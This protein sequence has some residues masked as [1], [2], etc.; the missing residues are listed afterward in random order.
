MCIGQ[1]HTLRGGRGILRIQNPHILACLL[2]PTD[3]FFQTGGGTV[4]GVQPGARLPCA[5]DFLFQTGGPVDDAPCPEIHTEVAQP[6]PVHLFQKG[7]EQGI[8]QTVRPFQHLLRLG[9]KSR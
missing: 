2:R 8:I 1:R 9:Q 7:L 5:L 3:C 4:G 6:F